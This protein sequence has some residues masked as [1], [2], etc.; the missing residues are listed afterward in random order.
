M[1]VNFRKLFPSFRKISECSRTFSNVKND[2]KTEYDAVVVGAGHN[3]LVTAAYLQK[4]GKN[5]CVLERRHVIG[6][7]AVTEEIVPGFK[8]SRASYVL[9]LLRPQIIADLELKKYG[10]KV[11]LRDPNSYTPLIKPG[12]LNGQARSL[13]LGRDTEENVRQIAQFSKKDA[14]MF[15]QY[16]HMLERI[17]AAIEPLLDS[18]PVYLPHVL[19]SATFKEKLS[20]LPSLKSLIQSVPSEENDVAA[21]T[22]LMTAPTTKPVIPSN[23]L[24]RKFSGKNRV[25]MEISHKPKVTR[26]DICCRLHIYRNLVRMCVLERRHVIGGAAVTEE[27]V[28]GFKFSRASYVLSL[29]RPQIIADLELKKYGLKV[30]LRDPNSYTPLIKPGGLNGQA[31]SLLL[32]RDTEENVRQIAQFSKKDAEMFVQYEHMLERIVAAIEPLLDSNPVYLPHVLSSATFKEK[33][34][35]LPSLKSLIQSVPSEENDVAAFTELMTA[36]TTKV[37]VLFNVIM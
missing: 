10:L 31:R 7:A 1:I 28:P 29:L 32:G 4:S 15:V 19:S 8:F 13:L 9:S 26:Y 16:E 2:L 22:E 14:E 35:Q 23:T 18:N 20:Q 37:C 17:V 12:G 25:I 30:Y 11:Y 36:P 24:Y 34:S 5:V 3:G 27:I 21:F 6:G 33:L